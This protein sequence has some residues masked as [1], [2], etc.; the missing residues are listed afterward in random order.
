MDKA[1][2]KSLLDSGFKHFDK[3][4]NPC[5]T[6]SKYLVKDGSVFDNEEKVSSKIEKYSENLGILE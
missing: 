5:E 3:N 4:G 2:Y 6:E 1:F